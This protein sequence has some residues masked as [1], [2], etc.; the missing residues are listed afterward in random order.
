[1]YV[2]MYVCM[3]VY[4]HLYIY[5]YII[6]YNY[7]YIY[8]YNY[9]YIIICIFVYLFIYMYYANYLCMKK[10]HVHA[11][12][13]KQI[14]K[15]VSTCICTCLSVQRSRES[16]FVNA[17]LL[18]CSLLYINMHAHMCI[19]H[20]SVLPTYVCINMCMPATLFGNPQTDSLRLLI[21]RA[22]RFCTQ[23]LPNLKKSSKSS[24]TPRNHPN[25][26]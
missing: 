2:C 8:I 5:I 20:V 12:M 3:Y 19:L 25:L 21:F 4:T 15:S 1:M 7:I 17:C 23:I 14:S 9:I 24:L 16:C 11:H 10:R 22:I 13:H 18:T 6:I 26:P